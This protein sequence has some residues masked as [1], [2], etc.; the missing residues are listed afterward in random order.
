MLAPVGV[1]ALILSPIV[2][3]TVGKVDPRRYVTFAFLV[4]AF[5]MWLRSRYNTQ[6]DYFTLMMPTVIQGVSMA[7]FF[8][9][10]VT[11]TLSGLPPDRIASAS[12][13]SNF[14]RITAGAFG[15][16]ISTTAQSAVDA[17]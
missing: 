13:L 2:G 12:G 9:P 6:A 8:I 11:I 7:F 1:L 14:M 17:S 5:V 4:F 15:A 10:L 3:K 16:S